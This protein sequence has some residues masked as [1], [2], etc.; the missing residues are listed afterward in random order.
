MM[1]GDNQITVE[2]KK[3]GWYISFKYT[4]RRI[5]GLLDL[6]DAAIYKAE[7]VENKYNNAEDKHKKPKG[8]HGLD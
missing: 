7:M 5:I 6:A 8:V 1:F 3:D 4:D 2:H